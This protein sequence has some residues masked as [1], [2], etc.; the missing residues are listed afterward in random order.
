MG[1]ACRN[2]CLLPLNVLIARM[3]LD[4]IAA[5]VSWIF[6]RL[7]SLARMSPE[8]PPHI[9]DL[10][11]CQEATVA[12][13]FWDIQGLLPLVTHFFLPENLAGTSNHGLYLWPNICCYLVI[14]NLHRPLF[15][16]LLRSLHSSG[17]TTLMR[18]CLDRDVERQRERKCA[19]VLVLE[20]PISCCVWIDAKSSKSQANQS[21][22]CC[23]VVGSW[24]TG[25][26]P[27]LSPPPWPTNMLVLRPQRSMIR[28]GAN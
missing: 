3:R 17:W 25:R 9:F 19:L 20:D 12:G 16:V 24:R 2:C 21:S 23:W 11:Y 5:Y 8:V 18:V 28:K 6:C 22:G 10:L 1:W 15:L 7:K 27:V 4:D 14:G 13:V 26:S